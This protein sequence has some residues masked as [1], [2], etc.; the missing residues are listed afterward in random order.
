MMCTRA[1][2]NQVVDFEIS[3]YHNGVVPLLGDAGNLAGKDVLKLQQRRDNHGLATAGLQGS[4]A[5]AVPDCKQ[6]W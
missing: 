3:V 6:P 5:V 4:V 2:V 1:A